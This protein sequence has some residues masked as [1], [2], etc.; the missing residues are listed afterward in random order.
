MKKKNNKFKY[1]IFSIILFAVFLGITSSIISEEKN[2]NFFEKAIKDS[3]TFI[4][5]IFYSPIK[6]V[7][8]EIIK[9]K[10]SKNTENYA[11]KIIN[12]IK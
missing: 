9:A 11:I 4:Q 3:T 5:K 8:D 12:L 2:L 6:Y 7:K 1:I 10:G